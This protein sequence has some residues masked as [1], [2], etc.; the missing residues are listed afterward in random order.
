MEKSTITPCATEEENI[1]VTENPT[2]GAAST[3]ETPLRVDR[4]PGT[5][6]QNSSKNIKTSIL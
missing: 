6:T 2:S 5:S 4:I 1:N 3:G